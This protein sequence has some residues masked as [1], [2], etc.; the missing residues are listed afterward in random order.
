LSSNLFVLRVKYLMTFKIYY[1]ITI[2]QLRIHCRFQKRVWSH[3]QKNRFEVE[4]EYKQK[5]RFEV[6]TKSQKTN[7]LELQSHCEKILRF[8]CLIYVEQ[9]FFSEKNSYLIY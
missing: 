4:T 7:R 3:K 8:F 6:E 9:V 2:E 5:N 1:K